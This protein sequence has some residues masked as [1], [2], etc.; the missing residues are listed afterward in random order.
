MKK[1]NYY[2]VV[3]AFIF[4]SISTISIMGLV[5]LA[6]APASPASG[7]QPVTISI[8]KAHELLSNYLATARP[9]RGGEESDLIRSIT[10]D[11]TQLEAMNIIVKSNPSVSGFRIYFGLENTDRLGLVVGVDNSGTDIVGNGIYRTNSFMLGLCPPI[12]DQNS[13]IVK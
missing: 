4:G 9:T 1:I 3:V 6:N 10:I 12:C 7:G 13:P 11:E 5:S 8:A 2:S